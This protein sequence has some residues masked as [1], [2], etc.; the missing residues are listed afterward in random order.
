MSLKRLHCTNENNK[1]VLYFFHVV[2]FI[3]LSKLIFLVYKYVFFQE[4]VICIVNEILI[5]CWSKQ[6]NFICMSY[7]PFVGLLSRGRMAL[8]L[9]SVDVTVESIILRSS[10]DQSPKGVQ[11]LFSKAALASLIWCVQL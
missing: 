5:N 8:I 1:Q 4:D 9:W 3:A 2:I 6:N 10:I 11:G 7:S